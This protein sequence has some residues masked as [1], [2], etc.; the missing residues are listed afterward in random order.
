[1]ALFGGIVVVKPLVWR[2]QEGF[3][4]TGG[5]GPLISGRTGLSSIIV[6]PLDEFLMEQ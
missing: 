4:A 2:D 6:D 3:G 1:M 5:G